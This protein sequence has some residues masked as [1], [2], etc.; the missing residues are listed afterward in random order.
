MVD[1][2]NN[3]R[4]TD[5]QCALAQ[6]QLSR[7]DAYTDHRRAIAHRYDKAF[8]ANRFLTP[9]AVA[10]DVRHA[11]HLYV[12]QLNPAA[13]T[14]DR[15]VIFRALRAEGISVNVH[16]IPV[17]LHHYYRDLGWHPGQCPVAGPRLSILSYPSSPP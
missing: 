8:A 12:I 9:L 7:L 17:H 11:Y 5:F 2:G 3:Y 4:I 16:Y 14:V 6:S 1:L 15:G 10:D 13:L